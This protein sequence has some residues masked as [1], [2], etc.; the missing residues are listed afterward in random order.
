MTQPVM[1]TAEVTH[2]SRRCRVIYAD[3]VRELRLLVNHILSEEGHTV[4]CV[5]DGRCALEEL[6]RPDAAYDIVITDHNMPHMSGLEL[7]RKLRQADFPGKIIVVS[8]D[9][10]MEVDQAYHELHVDHVFKKP[11]SFTHLR[12]L[13]GATGQPVG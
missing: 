8:S 7:V 13:V 11:F 5:A 2:P 4:K 10:S 12:N 3:D 6:Q 9:L 1:K